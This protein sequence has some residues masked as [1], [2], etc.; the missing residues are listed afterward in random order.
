MTEWAYI[1]ADAES[2]DIKQLIRKKRRNMNKYDKYT[3]RF[4]NEYSDDEMNSILDLINN[5]T[6]LFDKIDEIYTKKGIE[7]RKKQKLDLIPYKDNLE[8][9]NEMI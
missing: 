8:G 3:H 1:L 2:D 9:F 6:I 5:D 4:S 7:R